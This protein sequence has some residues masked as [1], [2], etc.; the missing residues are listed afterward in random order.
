[1]L[2]CRGPITSDGAAQ[3]ARMRAGGAVAG[4]PVAGKQVPRLMP[5][6]PHLRRTGFGG[7]AGLSGAADPRKKHAP[8]L[9]KSKAR[10]LP[11]DAGGKLDAHAL[12][13]GAL[14][15]DRQIRIE[16]DGIHLVPPSEQ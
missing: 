10:P 7:Q 2:S 5:K 16:P 13:D 4:K 9:D 3:M 1:M 8:R 14:Y 11:R 12:V 15:K 6:P